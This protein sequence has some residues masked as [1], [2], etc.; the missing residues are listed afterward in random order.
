MPSSIG[1]PLSWNLPS[2][3]WK[4]H[5][6]RQDRQRTRGRERAARGTIRSSSSSRRRTDRGFPAAIQACRPQGYY[7]EGGFIHHQL[8]Q[9]QEIAKKD[10][11]KVSAG[12]LTGMGIT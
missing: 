9:F 2:T 1:S 4:V 3:T 6:W 11:V 10:L 12:L 5:R 8:T 7:Q